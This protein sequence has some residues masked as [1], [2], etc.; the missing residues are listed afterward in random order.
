M[1]NLVFCGVT[2]LG[3]GGFSAAAQ[4]TETINVPLLIEEGGQKRLFELTREALSPAPDRTA[5]RCDSPV[6]T[7]AASFPAAPVDGS[8][9][10]NLNLVLYERGVPHNRFTRRML[11]RWVVARL[12]EDA[13][14][15][16]VARAV[17]ATTVARLPRFA[18]WAQFETPQPEEAPRLAFALRAVPGVQWAEPQLARQHQ[19]KLVPND[20]LFSQ[21]WHLLNTGQHGGAVGLDVQVTNVWDRWRGTGVRLG[22]VDVGVQGEHPDLAPNF[23]AAWSTNLNSSSYSPDAD[24]HGT[25]VAGLAVARGNNGHGVSGVAL[26]AALVDIRLVADATVDAQDAEAMLHGSQAIQIKN[27]SWGATDGSGTLE[28]PGPLMA[29][30]LAQG[31]ATGRGGAGTVYVFA[32]G[33][34]RQSGD[35]V[36]YDGYANSP[37]V[38]AVGAV[39]DLGQQ[40]S[41]SEPGA[42]LMVVAPSS[43][44]SKLCSGGRQR[45][46]TTDPTGDDGY[47]YI[48]A[49]CD[50][51][52]T[53]YTQ[54]FTGTSGVAPIVSGVVALMLQA[55]PALGWRDVKEVLLRSAR[56][57][58]ATDPD[59][60]TNAAGIHHNTGSAPAWSARKPL[61]PSPP[62]G[63]TSVPW[64][65]SRSGRPASISPCR[66]T[67]R[68]A[69][70]ALSR[71]PTPAFAWRL[72]PS[73]SPCRTRVMGTWQ[74]RSLRQMAPPAAYRKCTHP[75]GPVTMA[76]SSPPRGTGAN[77]RKASGQ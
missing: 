67:T 22:V 47:N 60:W 39:S 6:A 51:T 41:Y 49:Y 62:T 44:G 21:Q 37:Y 5:P 70:S 57:V 31:T 14:L 66:T 24:C 77:R 52:D 34:G 72:S 42:C 46:T 20:P 56:L 15:G 11:T 18:G 7:P 55:N 54:D 16:E 38:V 61:S 71:S 25:A 73:R 9:G 45:L 35:D 13:D 32:G 26:D 75:P 8:S 12:T 58:S 76:G 23:D 69:C 29:A 63:S 53:D 33:N 10:T 65:R 48:R 64:S 74:S 17:G 36:N 28:G 19:T 4:S 50:V 1:K 43:S 27:N 30:A 40:A 2:V 3:L 68:L 59:W